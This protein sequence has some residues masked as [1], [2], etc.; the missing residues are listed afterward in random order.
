MI[1]IEKSLLAF[2]LT[3]LRSKFLRAL[4]GFLMLNVGET[5]PCRV[6]GC[7]AFLLLVKTSTLT[8]LWQWNL[9][10]Q[11][12]FLKKNNQVSVQ[13]PSQIMTGMLRN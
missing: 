1:R 4:L 7:I 12:T 11:A 8:R 5:R 3:F 10:H 6:R 2:K 9:T 13:F